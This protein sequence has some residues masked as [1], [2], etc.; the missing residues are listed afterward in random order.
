MPTTLPRRIAR[1][2]R[3]VALPLVI[4]LLAAGCSSAA[5]PT[6]AVSPAEPASVVPGTPSA[7]PTTTISP[8][9]TPVSTPVQAT[10]TLSLGGPAGV[11]GALSNAAILCN[12]PSTEGLQISVL[13]RP[14]DPNLSVYIFISPGKLT[15]R[16]DSGAGAT[17]VERDFAGTGVTSFDPAK[18]AQIDATLTE[19]PT[20]GAHGTL[21]ILSSIRGSV[22][23]GSQ[24]PGS[25]TLVLSGPTAKGTLAGGLDPVNVEC[26]TDT[27]GSRV[28]IIGIAQVGSTPTMAVISISSGSF[29]V[30]L[31][32]DGFFK[33]G[34]TATAKLTP[35]GGDV[36]GDVAEQQAAGTTSAA[37]TIHM[38]GSATCGTRVGG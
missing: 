17:Y 19:V 38:T 32:N 18:G 1:A 37:H 12:M 34:G 33:S 15:V 14:V 24:L 6:A 11:T 25:S 20:T 13:A 30:S 31:S 7:V 4:G 27:Y 5:T 22:D 29:T 21:G 35:A 2:L 8:S 23:C 3:P 36:D 10:Q 28:Q 9:A 16:F 26:V